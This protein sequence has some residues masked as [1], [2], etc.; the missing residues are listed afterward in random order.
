MFLLLK[1]ILVKLLQNL[2]EINATGATLLKSLTAVDI[3]LPILQGFRNI[4]LKELLRKAAEAAV[5]SMLRLFKQPP[6]VLYK[7]GYS[8]K[9]RNIQRKTHALESLF[10]K[11]AGLE[12][13]QHRCFAVNIVKFLRI[14]ILKSI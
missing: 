8:S 3:F 10:D 2:W 1:A 5:C 12:S 7:N 4:F 9:F 14:S 13:L 6:K 11:V